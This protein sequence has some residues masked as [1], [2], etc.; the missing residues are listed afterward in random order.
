[1]KGITTEF[2][3]FAKSHENKKKFVGYHTRILVTHIHCNELCKRVNCI[4]VF[5]DGRME[6]FIDVECLEKW[7]EN[8]I[9]QLGRNGALIYIPDYE[10][11]DF[12]LEKII[13]AF[14]KLF[15]TYNA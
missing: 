14:G 12:Y 3:E 5:I 15:I 7:D 11:I 2:K 4:K 6:E 13:K 1:M 9:N 8:A 10:K